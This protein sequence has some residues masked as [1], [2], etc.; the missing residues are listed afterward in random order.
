MM[1]G[2]V[3]PDA[4]QVLVDVVDQDAVDGLAHGHN[5]NVGRYGTAPIELGVA[6]PANDGGRPGAARP[7]ELEGLRLVGIGVL[8]EMLGCSARAPMFPSS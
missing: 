2:P 6:Q 4:S 8:H 7:E 3:R 5:R 1:V